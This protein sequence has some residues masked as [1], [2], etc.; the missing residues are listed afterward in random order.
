VISLLAIAT[1]IDALAAGISLPMLQQPLLPSIA[2]IGV[3]T[4]LLS[5]L[6]LFAGRHFGVMLGRRLDAAGGV[7]LLGIGCKILIQHLSS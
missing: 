3:V 7:V 2:V 6:G 1:S 4:A 5:A